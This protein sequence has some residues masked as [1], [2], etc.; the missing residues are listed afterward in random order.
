MDG[1]I[2]IWMT[3][4]FSMIQVDNSSTFQITVALVFRVSKVVYVHGSDKEARGAR[5]HREDVNS[6]GRL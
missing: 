5:R 6:C 2:L 4:M 1:S 3:S